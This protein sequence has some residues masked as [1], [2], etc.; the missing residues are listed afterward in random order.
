MKQL[1]DNVQVL[2]LKTSVLSLK[3][4]ILLERLLLVQSRAD[5][6]CHN[7]RVSLSKGMACSAVWQAL[8]GLYINDLMTITM[9]LTM[10]RY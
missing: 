1:R 7:A 8:R 6:D 3:Y 2:V 9:V 5:H 4:C 10:I